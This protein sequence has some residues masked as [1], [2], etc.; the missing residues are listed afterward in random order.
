MTSA[1]RAVKAELVLSVLLVTVLLSSPGIGTHRLGSVPVTEG[2]PGCQ[3]QNGELGHPIMHYT[4]EALRETLQRMKAGRAAT[5]NPN[6]M[7]PATARLD[8]LPYLQYTPVQRD[9]GWAGNCWVWA[10][11]GVMEV[12]LDVQ[13]GVKDRLSIQYFDSNYQA[14]SGC[15]WAGCGGDLD[16]FSTFYS[17]VGYAIPW[18]NTNAAYGDTYQCCSGPLQGGYSCPCGDSCP[19][20]GYQAGTA[21]PAASIS[22]SPSYSFSSISDSW[23]YHPMSPP[24]TAIAAIKNILSQNKAM[25]FA[26]SLPDAAAWTDFGNFWNNQPE[27]VSYDMGKYNGYTYDYGTGGGHAVL[28]VGYDD[29]NP[30]DKYW[31]MVNSWG[32]TPGRPNGIFH[33]K[34]DLN[35][36]SLLYDPYY[37]SWFYNLWWGTL[38][39]SWNPVSFDYRLYNSGSSSNL[40]G[41][42]V[43]HGSSGSITISSTLV[44]G[45][46]RTVTLSCDGT[47]R[48]DPLPSG[49]TCSFSLPSG[50]PSF[51]ST[52]TILTSSSTPPG[53]YTLK[54]SGTLLPRQTL[55]ILLVT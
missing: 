47:A 49:V 24:A 33:V 2:I 10:S 48:G 15:N 18:S 41:I 27:S 40:G 25:Y 6:I 14:G 17:G 51:V 43:V 55:F 26:F 4:P 46:T 3:A 13:T 42:S 16:E 9:Q 52:L 11:T 44:N 7:V 35:Y 53:Y 34:M 36:D 54:V 8:L 32:T 31:I 1:G 12:S 30:S 50:S 23:L 22:T 5:T 38:S 45:P 20:T 39:I 29:T 28:L 19:C 21:V 37:S